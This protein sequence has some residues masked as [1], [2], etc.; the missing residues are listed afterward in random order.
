[1]TRSRS[2]NANRDLRVV[3]EA[4][5]ADCEAYV[6]ALGATDRSDGI[7]RVYRLRRGQRLPT[8]ESF[9]VAG[10]AGAVEKALPS[11]PAWWG[12]LDHE[13]LTLAP[14]SGPAPAHEQLQVA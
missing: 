9:V 7:T 6:R 1:M 14:S 13:Q 3:M 8:R 10:P 12:E 4:S 5:W 2:P 11:F